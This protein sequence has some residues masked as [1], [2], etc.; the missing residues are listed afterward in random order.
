MY[1]SYP[2]GAQMPDPAPLVAPPPV[3][4]AVRLMY[5]GAALSVA[6]LIITLV[7]VGSLKSV[8][9]KANPTFTDS[10]LHT[11]EVGAVIVYVVSGL[12][13]VG[14]WIWMALKNQAG[15]SWARITATV[16]FGLNTLF[17]LLSLVR[18]HAGLALVLG[19]LDWLVGLGATILLWRRES[20][21]FFAPRA[22]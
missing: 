20:S 9:L 11:A 7:T 6:G 16:F 3:Q 8:I 4:M 15:K 12:I 2:S 21:Q 5:I 10:Q 17:L 13:A 22:S 18:P 14:L 19:V 1:E